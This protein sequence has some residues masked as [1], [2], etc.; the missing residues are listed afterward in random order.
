MNRHQQHNPYTLDLAQNGTIDNAPFI[1]GRPIVV[2]IHGYTGHRDFS[3]NTEIRPGNYTPIVKSGKTELL[4]HIFRIPAYFRDGEYNIVSV[5]YGPLALEPCYL[6]AVKNLP[7][8]ARCTAKLLDT[9]VERLPF[10]LR[11]I[12]IIG[13]SLGAQVSGMISNYV[14]SGRLIRITGL[15]PAKPL[16]VLATD[17]HRLSKADATFVDVIHTDVLQR[18]ILQPIGHADFYVNG[19]IEQPGCKYAVNECK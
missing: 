19:G 15:D 1:R 8:V 7:I 18:G 9:I 13:F 4:I 11:Q 6:Q 17:D 14:R 12:H 5:D 16:F 10:K 3:P 2:L